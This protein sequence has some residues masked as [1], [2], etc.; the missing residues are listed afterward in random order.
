MTSNIQQT[1]SEVALQAWIEYD[2]FRGNYEFLSYSW[3]N[4]RTT[5]GANSLLAE[6]LA[7]RLAYANSLDNLRKLGFEPSGPEP[8]P[9]S[10]FKREG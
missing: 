1:D 9:E 8:I 7:A 6:V 4:A 5:K 10:R 2:K 3:L